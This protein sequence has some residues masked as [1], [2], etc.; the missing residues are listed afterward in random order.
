MLKLSQ[1]LPVTPIITITCQAIGD[2]RAC[3]EATWKDRL[4][5]KLGVSLC[6]HLPYDISRRIDM[7][8]GTLPPMVLKCHGTVQFLTSTLPVGKILLTCTDGQPKTWPHIYARC[9]GAETALQSE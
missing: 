3:M 5:P 1:N 2:R 8:R 9:A 4:Q 6:H 7:Y